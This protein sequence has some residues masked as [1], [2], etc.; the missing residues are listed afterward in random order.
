MNDANVD[1]ASVLT[2]FMTKAHEEKI[3]AMK[4]IEDQYKTQLEELHEKV[5]VLEDAASQTTPTSGNSFAFPA[6]NKDL[7]EKVAAYRS[8]ISDYIVKAQEEKFKAVKRAEE[9]ITKPSMRQS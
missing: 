4:R 1:A 5:S 9:N 6:T 3:A 8:F 7:T 2:E